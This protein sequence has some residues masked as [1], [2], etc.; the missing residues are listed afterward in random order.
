MRRDKRER[1]RYIK[2]TTTHNGTL[3]IVAE[4]RKRGHVRLN[5]KLEGVVNSPGSN[6]RALAREQSSN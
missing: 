4:S 3:N 6:L 2:C 1:E 5:E